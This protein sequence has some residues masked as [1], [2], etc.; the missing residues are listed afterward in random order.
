MYSV[1]LG[2]Y[3]WHNDIMSF[4]VANEA[5]FVFCADVRQSLLFDTASQSTL[6]LPTDN[7]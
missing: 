5:L 4:S 1:R 6:I 3:E 2:W 7:K